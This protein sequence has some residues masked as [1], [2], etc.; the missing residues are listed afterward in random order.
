[1]NFSIYRNGGFAP[2]GNLTKGNCQ[3]LISQETSSREKETTA[4]VGG[5]N[6]GATQFP[7]N[8]LTN[9]GNPEIKDRGPTSKQIQQ[10]FQIQKQEP[11]HIRM[12]NQVQIQN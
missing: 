10:K 4:L 5:I 7:L 2:R 1:M 3:R 8:D 11:S 12:Q 9:K 6:L